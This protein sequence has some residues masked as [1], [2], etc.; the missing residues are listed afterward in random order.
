VVFT[1]YYSSWDELERAIRNCT[2]CPLHS[3]RKN[4]VPGEGSK[5]SKIMFIGEAPGAT[6]DEMGRPFVGVAGK[7]LTLALESAGLKR[8]TVYI[9]NVV[10][11]RPPQNRE[12]NDYEIES[13]RIYLESQIL[14]LRP[15]IIITLGN[16]AGRT[17]FS[18]GKKPWSGVMRMRGRVYEL[19]ILGLDIRVLATLHPAAALYNPSLRDM[20]FNDLKKLKE[21]L[22]SMEKTLLEEPR[23]RVVEQASVKDREEK[24]SKR[25]IIDYIKRNSP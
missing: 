19:K 8:E 10:K 11:C 24:K 13:C 16:I 21:L 2:R 18:L 7:L 9:T 5:E 6:E 20:L 14:L 25:T 23:Q 17:V 3:Y 4:A 1:S 22:E 15:K 12:P